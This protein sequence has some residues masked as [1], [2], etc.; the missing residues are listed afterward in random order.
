MSVPYADGRTIP[1]LFGGVALTSGN[2]ITWNS[3]MTNV[4]WDSLG[5]NVRVTLDFWVT[6]ND[7][8]IHIDLDQNINIGT[9]ELTGHVAEVSNGIFMNIYATTSGSFLAFHHMVANEATRLTWTNIRFPTTHRTLG[10]LTR[11]NG[12]GFIM[13]RIVQPAGS[14]IFSTGATCI[15]FG[16][17]FCVI[18]YN[19]APWVRIFHLRDNNRWELFPLAPTEGPSGV[20]N[21]VACTADRRVIAIAGTTAPFLIILRL[22]AN[23]S[24]MRAPITVGT[25]AL[26]NNLTD[27]DITDDGTTVVI[28]QTADP[29]IRV[30]RAAAATREASDTATFV[31]TTRP[32]LQ[33]TS[34]TDAPVRNLKISNDGLRL[35]FAQSGTTTAN[36][37]NVILAARTALFGAAATAAANFTSMGAAGRVINTR[38]MQQHGGR[39]AFTADG[40]GF[41]L[42]TDAV[43]FFRMWDIVGVGTS[44]TI[45]PKPVADHGPTNSFLAFSKDGRLLISRG[46]SSNQQIIAIEASSDILLPIDH[47]ADGITAAGADLAI[48]PDSRYVG[49]VTTSATLPV[50]IFQNAAFMAPFVP[51]TGITITSSNSVEAGNVLQ[52]NAQT[53]GANA[54]VR[55]I[56]FEVIDDGGTGAILL[57]ENEIAPENPGIIRMRATIVDGGQVFSN[58]TPGIAGL[59]NAIHRAEHELPD[60]YKPKKPFIDAL[61]AA[62]AVRYKEPVTQ[63][64]IDSAT[65]NL[66]AAYN[67]IMLP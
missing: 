41:A 65:N 1:M 26:A 44:L 28:G 66:I 6:I 19:V 63:E 45:S 23:G 55:F 64:E 12:F 42:F 17:D 46:V 5:R 58:I 3:L 67:S 61:E 49:I 51:A 21:R 40:N 9:A 62:K 34:G 29:W 54:S 32:D 43:P 39:I 14:H 35:V 31:L 18:G 10:K 4:L 8:E 20:V 13:R 37:A 33:L 38:R 47:P 60:G 7:E 2:V 15:A 27:I 30:Y 52:V 16:D 50:V 22:Q 59:V 24:Y 25:P 36:N 11:E 57:R 56:R 48:S 53:E